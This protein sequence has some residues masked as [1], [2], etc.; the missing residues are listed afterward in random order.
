MGQMSIRSR[1][2]MLLHHSSQ[3]LGGVG[4]HYLAI[5][6]QDVRVLGTRNIDHAVLE[7][8]CDHYF[9]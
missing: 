8:G 5:L 2:N 9:Q 7:L 3:L 4:I 1:K 6:A